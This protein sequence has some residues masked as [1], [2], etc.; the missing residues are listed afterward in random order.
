VMP[1]RPDIIDRAFGAQPR[2]LVFE[3][4]LPW[5][6]EEQLGSRRI[7]IPMQETAAQAQPAQ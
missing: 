5:I 7:T 4:T 1:A 2:P 6:S 3:R